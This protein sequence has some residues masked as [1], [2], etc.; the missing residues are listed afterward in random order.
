MGIKYPLQDMFNFKSLIAAISVAAALTVFSTPARAGS[1]DSVKEFAQAIE[2][3]SGQKPI[4]ECY[5]QEL[6]PVPT[7]TPSREGDAVF[8]S[9][10]AL[11]AGGGLLIAILNLN[12]T[13]VQD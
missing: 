3:T 13:P 12:K 10:A 7:Q 2:Q 5:E 9:L 1:C 4:V 6:T 8:L 11:L